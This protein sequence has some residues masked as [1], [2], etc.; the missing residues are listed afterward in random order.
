MYST[1]MWYA[2]VYIIW[3]KIMS[4]TAYMSVFGDGLWTG[5]KN[6]V[7]AAAS[8][9]ESESLP[10]LRFEWLTL[11]TLASIVFYTLEYKMTAYFIR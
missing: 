11:E 8:M 6:L 7:Q 1:I 2:L 9:N 4:F 5:Q 10:P 3:N